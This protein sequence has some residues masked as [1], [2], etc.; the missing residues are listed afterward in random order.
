ME[1]KEKNLTIMSA[2]KD[3]ILPITSIC[4][5]NCIFCSHRG[6][7][8]ELEVYHTGHIKFAVIKEVASYLDSE[9]KIVIGESTTKICE[10]EPLL[11]PKFKQIIEFLRLKFPQS[12]LKITTNATLL[13]SEIIEFLAANQPVELNLSLNSSTAKGRKKL[14]GD[15]NFK[16]KAISLLKQYKLKFHGS[17]VAMPW[18]VGEKD[19]L[20]TI[21]FLSKQNALSIR[22]FIPGY[23]KLSPAEIRYSTKEVNKIKKIIKKIKKEHQIA[24]TLEPIKVNDLKAKVA[25]VIKD[26]P[27]DKAGVKSGDEIISIKQEE[28]FSRVSAFNTIYKKENPILELKRNN[29]ILNLKLNKAKASFSGLVMNYDYPVSKYRELFYE[30]KDSQASNILFLTS[31]LAAGVMNEVISL[32]NRELSKHNLSQQLVENKFFGGSI[33]CAGLL[34]V[35]DFVQALKNRRDLDEFDLILLPSAPFDYKGDDLCGVNYSSLEDEFDLAL[36]IID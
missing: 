9:Q 20:D 17:I 15:N 22:V 2:A 7:P 24:I 36:Q 28:V 8:P 13:N 26:S 1:S 21:L 4:N 30:L 32:L 19:L 23:T 31:K 11:H 14:M 35:S 3:N 10:G 16:Q 18:I 12:K 6:N 29:N 33:A 34:V 27:V 5:L 25:G